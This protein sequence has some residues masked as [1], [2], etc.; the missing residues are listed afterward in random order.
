MKIIKFLLIHIIKVNN[1]IIYL[2]P[3]PPPR[4]REREILRIL[5]IQ[6][7]IQ[8]LYCLIAN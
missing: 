2:P 6:K 5:K 8:M 3:P 7:R 1:I 4:E